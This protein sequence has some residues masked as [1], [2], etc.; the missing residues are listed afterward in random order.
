MQNLFAENIE[1]L[2]FVNETEPS[3]KKIN[4]FVSDVTRGNIQDILV[5]GSITESTKLVLANA[6]YFKGQWASKFS[7]ENTKPRIF[8]DFGKTPVY[9]DM[10]HQR[11]YFNYGKIACCIDRQSN[12]K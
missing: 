5:P 6:A 8:Y 12:A 2:D 9:V 1:T 11:G 7:P 10:M 3:R 4:D